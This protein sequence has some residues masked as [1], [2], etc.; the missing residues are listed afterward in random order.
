METKSTQTDFTYENIILSSLDI[1]PVIRLNQMDK[2]VDIVDTFDNPHKIQTDY[3]LTT[4]D[5]EKI[6][7]QVLPELFEYTKSNITMFNNNNDYKNILHDFLYDLIYEILTPLF[8]DNDFE[9]DIEHIIPIILNIFYNVIPRRS[10]KSNYIIHPQNDKIKKNI[11]KKLK[12][13]DEINDTLPEQRTTKWY[14]MR[15]NLL[16]ASSIWKCLGS[17]CNKNSLIC[18]KCTP[19]NIEKYNSVNINSPLHWG[20]KYEP[21]AQLYYEYTYDAIIK[22][23]GCIPH[24]DK[25]NC[26][27]LGASPDGINIKYDSE[28]YGRMLEIKNIVNRDISGVPK[29]EYWI[30]TQLQMECCDLDECDFLECRFKEYNCEEDFIID[31]Q[32]FNK[33]NCG[34]FKGVFIQFYYNDKPHYEYPPFNITKKEFSKWREEIISKNNDKTWVSDIF[35]K[36]D[37][38]SC[39]LIQR[40]TVW[41]N[42]VLCEFKNIWDIIKKERVEGY[43]HRK[44]NKRIKKSIP[45]KQ[46]DENG[47]NNNITEPLKINLFKHI[48]MKNMNI[49]K[50]KTKA[51]K[52]NEKK[53]NDTIEF[54]IITK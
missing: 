25:T 23:Y 35:W 51:T 31:G 9:D 45:D 5:I 22:E 32:T 43:E 54:N 18:E 48:Q 13:I 46:L 34:K 3:L 2:L 26:Y 16:S 50:D 28:R 40:N 36:L 15:H 53:K 38:V 29:K 42:E 49:T 24:P 47:D 6:S 12:K 17:D 41:F 1:N 21:L 33:T 14:E 4:N 10:N 30:Q 8:P 27:F 7:E 19:L 20:Q 37:E 52:M 39:V 11:M 44:P